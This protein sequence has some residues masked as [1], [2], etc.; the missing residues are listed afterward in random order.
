MSAEELQ[1]QGRQSSKKS[2]QDHQPNTIT[3]SKTNR[4]MDASPILAVK[5]IKRGGQSEARPEKAAG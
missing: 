3:E 4:E 5:E 1:G 2:S